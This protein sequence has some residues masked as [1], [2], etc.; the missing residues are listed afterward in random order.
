MEGDGEFLL[1]VPW[2]RE[3]SNLATVEKWSIDSCILT[4]SMMVWFH[5]RNPYGALYKSCL[6]LSLGETSNGSCCLQRPFRI[7]LKQLL[8]PGSSHRSRPPESMCG[9]NAKTLGPG[10]RILRRSKYE[11]G[12]DRLTSAEGSEECHRDSR[13]ACVLISAGCVRAAI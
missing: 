10:G 12:V 7:S 6:A 1:E 9:P 5:T 4:M 13:A 2:W 8:K 3:T 11:I